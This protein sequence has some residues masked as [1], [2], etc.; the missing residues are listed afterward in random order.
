MDKE[1]AIELLEKQIK[2]IREVKATNRF[3][4]TYTKW[5]QDTIATIRNIFGDDKRHLDAFE[6]ISFQRDNSNSEEEQ[7]RDYLHDLERAEAILESFVEEI[8][9]FW[10]EKGPEVLSTEVPYEPQGK[11]TLSYIYHNLRIDKTVIGLVTAIVVGSFVFGV[12]AGQTSFVKELL[13]IVKQGKLNP[14]STPPV[15]EKIKGPDSV[16]KK[17]ELI[18]ANTPEFSEPTW[19]KVGN[20][21]IIWNGQVK[22][23]I[24]NVIESWKSADVNFILGETQKDITVKYP[25]RE[26]FSFQG[27]K[28]YVDLIDVRHNE[29]LIKITSEEILPVK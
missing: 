18:K 27:K 26:T 5:R 9:R 20:P 28:Y 13:E 14:P 4:T 17:P 10:T 16:L 11:L 8:Q 6:K 7:Q 19:I 1:K 2:K 24:T 25:R 21:T 15:T 12:I 23:T 29:A 3:G 22:I